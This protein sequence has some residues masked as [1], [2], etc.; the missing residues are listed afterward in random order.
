MGSRA[1]MGWEVWNEK[2]SNALVTTA[3]GDQDLG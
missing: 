3:K 2:N 1:I